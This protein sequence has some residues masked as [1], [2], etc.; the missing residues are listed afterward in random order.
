MNLFNAVSRSTLCYGAQAWGYKK[1]DQVDQIQRYFAKKILSLPKNTPNYVINLECGL[2]PITIFALK[3]HLNYLCNVMSNYHDNRLPKRIINHIR[4]NEGYLWKFWLDIGNK[5]NVNWLDD[6]VSL[7][8]KVQ[9][10]V[11]FLVQDSI[12]ESYSY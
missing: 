2:R 1:Y 8:S 7:S 11:D 12:N 10:V 4:V 5:G 3:L 9:K 6:S